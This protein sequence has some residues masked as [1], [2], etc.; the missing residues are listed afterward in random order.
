MHD[1]D[2]AAPVK[3]EG[4]KG[5]CYAC[6]RCG[7]RYDTT[8]AFRVTCPEV[9][10]ERRVSYEKLAELTGNE[11]MRKSLQAGA[12][13]GPAAGMRGANLRG[14]VRHRVRQQSRAVVGG[15]GC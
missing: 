1:I 13:K 2:W 9:P 3:R 14:T 6:R 7:G 11:Y 8:G 10:S 12:R 4:A 5:F 15:A